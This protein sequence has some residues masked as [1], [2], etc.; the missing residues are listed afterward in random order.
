MGSR[1]AY[2]VAVTHSI[3][4]FKCHIVDMLNAER[5]YLTLTASFW[6]LNILLVLQG[7]SWIEI[8]CPWFYMF[9]QNMLT[10]MLLRVTVL[11]SFHSWYSRTEHVKYA[12]GFCY[13]HLAW[14]N[15]VVTTYGE[16]QCSINMY[17]NPGYH[18]DAILQF[19]KLLW[20]FYFVFW[21]VVWRTAPNS[22]S[23]TGSQRRRS[24]SKFYKGPSCRQHLQSAS[25]N[26]EGL[27]T[28]TM[29]SAGFMC[30]ASSNCWSPWSWSVKCINKGENIPPALLV[31]LFCDSIH[32]SKYL[33]SIH[34]N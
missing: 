4:H 21:L 24:V 33:C 23:P 14:K 25:H 27:V 6:T 3:K 31:G 20:N 12:T 29:P 34:N 10:S 17:N 18:C 9:I 5:T 16:H 7:P 11:L 13:I 15:S 2:F 32:W 8:A 28:L 30:W 19:V 22:D 26:S 1:C